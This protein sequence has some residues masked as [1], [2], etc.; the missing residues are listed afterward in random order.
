MSFSALL[1]EKGLEGD[2]TKSPGTLRACGE[3]LGALLL[4]REEPEQRL[5]VPGACGSCQIGMHS[6]A[7]GRRWA[8]NCRHLRPT[9]ITVSDKENLL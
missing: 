6:V 4:S 9:G 5:Q 3:N 1:P 2:F 8:V 7:S